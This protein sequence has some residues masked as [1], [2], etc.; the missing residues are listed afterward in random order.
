MKF[1]PDLTA[2]QFVYSYN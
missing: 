1:N 2:M